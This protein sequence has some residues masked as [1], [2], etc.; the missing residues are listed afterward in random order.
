MWGEVHEARPAGHGSSR[1]REGK[2]NKRSHSRSCLEG[3]GW[4]SSSPHCFARAAQL[5]L[6]EERALSKLNSS[7]G[8]QRT[9]MARLADLQSQLAEES[10]WR[11]VSIQVAVA[12]IL[13]A[14]VV[15]GSFI[16]LIVCGKCG[17]A[18]SHGGVCRG[19][20]FRRARQLPNQ[21]HVS[22]VCA[23][24]CVCFYARVRVCAC[25]LVCMC[26]AS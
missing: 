9:Q 19:R 4:R 2:L 8:A 3:F 14:I 17:G 22:R 7:R 13:P 10:V 20:C 12:C 15:I 18:W 16:P 25:A 11:S 24:V 21:R 1:R 5:H 23:H 26:G 6:Q